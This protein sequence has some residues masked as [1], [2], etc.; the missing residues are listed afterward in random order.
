[1][2]EDGSLILIVPEKSL[3]FDHKR[4]ISKFDTILSQ[5]EKNVGEDD[6]STLPEILEKHDLSM[7]KPAGTFEQFKERSL[8]NFNNRC[9]HHYVYDKDLLKQMCSYLD[10]E[11]THTITKGI[12]I[13]FI[14]KKKA[15]IKLPKLKKV[16]EATV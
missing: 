2:K 12:D 13:W 8:D 10:C 4:D 14:M 15:K 5:Y 11:F 1:M 7:D 9:L 3:C 16:S 6:L